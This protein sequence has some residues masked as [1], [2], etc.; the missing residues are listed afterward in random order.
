MADRLQPSLH[1]LLLYTIKIIPILLAFIATLNIVLSLIGIDLPILSY[2]GG[3]SFLT[4]IFLY[5]ASAVFK[6]CFYHRTFLHYLL[7]CNVLNCIDI[8]DNITIEKRYTICI[9][10]VATYIILII[11]LI[12]HTNYE[13]PRK[14]DCD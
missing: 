13:L 6:F 3:I 9:T 11:L 5:L 8:Y 10:L 1:K 2:I 12:S 7:L 14:E 4:I